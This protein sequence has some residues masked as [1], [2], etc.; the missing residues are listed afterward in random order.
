MDGVRLPEGEVTAFLQLLRMALSGDGGCRV[1]EDFRLTE[2]QW[3]SVYDMAVR[4]SVQGMLFDVVKALPESAGVPAGLAV[5]WYLESRRIESGHE[6]HRKL[7]E[8]QEEAWKRAG[9][10]AV[11]VKGL[12]VA[13]YYPRPESRVL[14][15]IDWWMRTGTDWD[16]ALEV[17]GRNGIDYD[18][19]SDGDISY[20]LGGVVVEHHHRGYEI[21][22]TVGEL[23]LLSEHILHHAMVF[24]VGLRQ[25]CDY[26]YASRALEGQYDAAEY[27]AALRERGLC[28]WAEVLDDLVD[29]LARGAEGTADARKLLALVLADGDMG[30]DKHRRASGFGQRAAL[31]LRIAPQHFL[32]RWTGLAFGRLKRLF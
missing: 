30:L 27:R 21:D 22:G 19:D 25:V 7:V 6:L 32:S 12:A 20:E 13:K 1:P 11:M 10:D 24:G 28:R 18:T 4:Q 17:L 5:S 9:V 2:G 23:L 29:V 31:F 8:K 16:R 26:Y 15:D 14:G 3:R